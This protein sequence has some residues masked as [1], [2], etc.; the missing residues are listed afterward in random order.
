M[1]IFRENIVVLCCWFW[2]IPVW[3]QGPGW[4]PTQG[5][6]RTLFEAYSARLGAENIVLLLS[7]LVPYALLC[8]GKTFKYASICTTEYDRRGSWWPLREKTCCSRVLE[9]LLFRRIN[10]SRK[11]IHISIL[12]LYAIGI[13]FPLAFYSDE[14]HSPFF[15]DSAKIKCRFHSDWTINI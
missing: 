12:L 13:K 4:P 7:V 8:A 15:I 1:F 9:I 2:G 14:K 11:S 3:E 6:V 5:N 10:Y